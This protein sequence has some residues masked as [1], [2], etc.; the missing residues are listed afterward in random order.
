MSRQPEEAIVVPAQKRLRPAVF[1]DK[2]GT[3]VSDVPHN[4]DPATLSF[5]PRALPA[6]RLLSEAGFA[7]VIATNQPGI[8][9]GRFTRAE[10]VRLEH[11]LIERIARE[12]GVAIAGFYACPHAPGAAGEPA[13]LCRKPAAGLLRQAQVAHRLDLAGSWMVGDTLDDVEAGRR[14]GVRSVLLDVG[15][16]AVWRLTP[17]RTPDHCAADLLE[18]AEFI[19]ASAGAARGEGMPY[20]RAALPA[21]AHRRASA[22]PGA[23]G[24]SAAP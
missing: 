18:A 3:L 11:A 16:E 22:Q 21:A 23:T 1:L 15:N 5:T 6:L 14:A 20:E 24:P 2:D 10:L 17:L 8:A 7:L 9:S 4:V 19:V 12:C 13:C